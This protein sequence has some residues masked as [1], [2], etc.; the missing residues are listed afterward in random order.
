MNTHGK[1]RQVDRFML[2]MLSILNDADALKHGQ[3]YSS[4]CVTV[5]ILCVHMCGR[6]RRMLYFQR[7]SI[8]QQRRS[9]S[10]WFL[11]PMGTTSPRS[12]NWTPPPCRGRTVWYPGQSLT[13]M[14]KRAVLYNY[15]INQW[16][17]LQKFLCETTA[18]VHKHLGYQ[19]QRS[20][21]C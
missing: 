18:P 13:V 6:M 10:P 17:L 12:L 15:G 5:C 7:R 11:F 19:H 2:R 4:L 16:I 20:H 9:P 14:R 8:L 1:P 21:R 3:T